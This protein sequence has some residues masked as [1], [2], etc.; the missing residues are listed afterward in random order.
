MLQNF[1]SHSEIYSFLKTQGSRSGIGSEMS[2]CKVQ[3]WSQSPGPD[4]FFPNICSDLQMP[5][6]PSALWVLY[7]HFNSQV[8]WA[9]VCG[10]RKVC[11][12][13]IE[14]SAVWQI[15]L[16]QMLSVDRWSTE[17]SQVQFHWTC[18][19]WVLLRI[20]QVKGT[21]VIHSEDTKVVP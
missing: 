3:V 17:Q 12:L 9:M 19:S 14:G 11:Y 8:S 20:N 15:F 1:P 6:T 18:N 4:C 5:P 2:P 10:F 13:G 21:W 7:C 16:S